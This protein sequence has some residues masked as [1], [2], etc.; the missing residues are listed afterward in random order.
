MG[1]LDGKIALITGAAGGMGASHAELFVKEGAK[2][3]ITDVKDGKKTAEKIGE[4]C[5]FMHHDVTKREDWEKVVQ[6]TEK[7]YGPINILVNNAG[8]AKTMPW[9]EAEDKEYDLHYRINQLGVYLGM[10]ITAPSLK[11]AG[12]GSIV[13][14]SSIAGLFGSPAQSAY[15][16]TKFAVRG[17]TK[18]YALELG[19]FNIRVNSVHPGVVRTPMTM[20]NPNVDKQMVEDMGKNNA[21]GRIGDPIELSN[22]VLFLA[23]DES[24]FCTGSEFVADGG[25]T[26]GL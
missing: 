10:Q 5:T 11:K 15:T 7:L 19:Q 22:L 18:S 3:V 4:N 1:R 8:I 23:S 9:E 26:A 14:I 2:V 6:E 17:M 25:Q 20:E 24:S 12:N 13:N 21:L 16:A